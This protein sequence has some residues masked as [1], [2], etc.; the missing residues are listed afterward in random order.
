MQPLRVFAP[1]KVNLTLR[2]V[3][4]RD[5]GY[6]LLQSLAVFASVGDWLTAEPGDGEADAALTVSGPFG[7]ALAGDSDLSPLRAVRA[8]AQEVS[9]EAQAARLRA[10]RSTPRW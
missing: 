4:R 2:I 6:H 10:A 9:D 3:G 5:D 8:L 1:A 7:G